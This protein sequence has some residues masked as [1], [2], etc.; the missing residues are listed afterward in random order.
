[1]LVCTKLFFSFTF[2]FYR[3]LFSAHSVCSAPRTPFR[4]Y[5]VHTSTNTRS[6]TLKTVDVFDTASQPASQLSFSVVRLYSCIH[7]TQRA[8]IHA[9]IQQTVR[10]VLVLYT[11]TN[12]RGSSFCALVDMPYA[13]CLR[14]AHIMC[15]A[16]VIDVVVV[17][18]VVPPLNS[19]HERMRA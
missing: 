16:A 12:S 13:T 4:Y 8:C 15:V 19:I 11:T 14:N 18:I 2:V 3:M 10:V 6:S 7:H 1:M 5:I 17:I 9:C